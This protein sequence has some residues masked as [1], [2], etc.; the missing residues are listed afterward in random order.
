MNT[1][2]A[3]P[4][5]PHM[6]NPFSCSRALSLF[7]SAK[8]SSHGIDGHHLH[9]LCPLAILEAATYKNRAPKT[10]GGVLALFLRQKRMPSLVPWKL[11]SCPTSLL[12]LLP[13]NPT[14]VA[15]LPGILA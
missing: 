13:S 2:P 8:R 7:P 5:Y 6:R 3:L 12:Q 4:G 11:R 10:A 9:D 1:Q 15:Q 14:T